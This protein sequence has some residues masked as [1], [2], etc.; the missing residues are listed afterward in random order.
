MCIFWL[1]CLVISSSRI[2]FLDYLHMHADS[3][4]SDD[5]GRY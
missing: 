3:A 5:V 4:A 1:I 2:T